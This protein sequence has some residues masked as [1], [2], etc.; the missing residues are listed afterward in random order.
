[1][2][3]II[4]LLFFVAGFNNSMLSA[5]QDTFYI[6]KDIFPEEID[7]QKSGEINIWDYTSLKSP[8][9]IEKIIIPE[10]E[11]GNTDGLAQ[12]KTSN[13]FIQ[14]VK[15]DRDDLYLISQQN[16]NPYIKD[17]VASINYTEPYPMWKPSLE[18]GTMEEYSNTIKMVFA[19]DK[20]PDEIWQFIPESTKYL[21]L[22]IDLHG[23]IETDATGQI[24]TPGGFYNVS[25][26]RKLEFRTINYELLTPSGDWEDVTAAVEGVFPTTDQLAEIH[27][28]TPDLTVPVVSVFLENEQQINTVEFATKHKP[29][30]YVNKDLSK[31]DIFVY[32]NPSYGD[33]RLNILN[34]PSGTYKIKVFNILGSIIWDKEINI[35]N[36]KSFK[37]DLTHLKKGSYFYSLEDKNGNTLKSK[38]LVIIRS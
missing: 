1:M 33:V 6:M 25:R 36:E 30:I 23:Q 19:S 38:K 31:K 22:I 9:A 4:I 10:S 32:P 12:I 5:Q 37:L 3:R 21:R 8:Y 29:N 18:L 14:N 13:Y 35:D 34:Y 26:Q 24:Y 7:L 17:K 27:F 15:L 20:L 28:L 11:S 2:I 16:V